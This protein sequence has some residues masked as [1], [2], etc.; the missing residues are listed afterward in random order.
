MR[1]LEK[2]KYKEVYRGLCQYVCKDGSAESVAYYSLHVNGWGWRKVKVWGD[3]L[4]WQTHQHYKRCVDPW[5]RGLCDVWWA[6]E[7]YPQNK[8][9]NVVKL[10]VVK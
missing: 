6:N 1:F 7:Q 8:R 2:F 3:M 9:D 5:R 4:L 10:S